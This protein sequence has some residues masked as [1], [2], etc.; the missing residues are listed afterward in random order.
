MVVFITNNKPIKNTVPVNASN[1]QPSP[2]P[3]KKYSRPN[4]I[5][6]IYQVDSCQFKSLRVY[7]LESS[8]EFCHW[9]MKMQS[10]EDC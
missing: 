1:V 4:W 9:V 5:S 3:S 2:E 6:F 8:L 10:L 7:V